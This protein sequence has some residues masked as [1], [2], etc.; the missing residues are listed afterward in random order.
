MTDHRTMLERDLARVGPAPFGLDDVARRRDCMRRN[1][2]ITAGVVGFSVFVAAIW[3]VTTGGPFDRTQTPAVP[4]VETGPSETGPTVAP[5]AEQDWTGLGLPP[6]GAVPSTPE[7]GKLVAHY[8]AIHLGQVFVYADG[9][10]IWLPDQ[11]PI[12]EQRLSPEGLELVRTKDLTARDVIDRPHQP[13][14]SAWADPEP[15]AY[16]PSRYAVCGP[17]PVELLTL[18]PQQA[19][20]LLRGA[21]R[22]FKHHPD[23]EC[24]DVTIAEARALEGFLKEAEPYY[25]SQAPAYRL[26][27]RNGV[28]DPLIITLYPILPHGTWANHLLG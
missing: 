3:I 6:E 19:V 25:S 14:P 20:D 22:M 13:P 11:G 27:P 12:L 15:R 21:E 10:V 23:V 5:D 1:Q 4:G 18:L 24:F 7:E 26:D 17:E 8:A 16:V 9:R 2:R 28:D